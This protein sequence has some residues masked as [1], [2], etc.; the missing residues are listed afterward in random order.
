MLLEVHERMQLL[1]MLPVEGQYEALKTIRRQREMLSF[2]PE[3]KKVLELNSIT[4]LDGSVK[5]TWKGENAP[6]VVKDVTIDE[7]MTNLFRKKL[8]ELEA[9]GKLNES[10]MSLYEKFVIIGFK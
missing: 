2:T 4:N 10:L 9:E 8:A 1:Q 7:Y 3:E 5:T 6:K